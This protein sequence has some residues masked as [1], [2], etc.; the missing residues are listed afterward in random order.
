MRN[1]FLVILFSWLFSSLALQPAEAS[2]KS[3]SKQDLHH[4]IQ[5]LQRAQDLRQQ[6]I[7]LQKMPQ[8][9]PQMAAGSIAGT[10][11]GLNDAD[12]STAFVEAFTVDSIID[13]NTTYKALGTV[14]RDGSYQIDSLT[15]GRYYVCAWADGYLFKY[16][17]NVLVQSEAIPVTVDAGQVTRDIHFKMERIVPGTGAISGRV[18]RENTGAPIYGEIY[19]F[20]LEDPMASGWA[21]TDRSGYY[22][23][24]GLKT[25]NYYAYCWSNGCLTEY[26]DNVFTLEAATPIPVTEPNETREINFTLTTGGMISGQITNETGQPVAGVYVEAYTAKNDSTGGWEDGGITWSHYG[27]AMSDAEGRYLISGLYSADYFVRANYWNMW[28]S[29]GEWYPNAATQEEATPVP[30]MADQETSGIDF[31]LPIRNYS[32][33]IS[34]QVMNSA[35]EPIPGAYVQVQSTDVFPSMP[36]VWAYAYTDEKGNYRIENLPGGNY[37]ISAWAQSGWQF[38]QRWWQDADT[39]EQA[40]PVTVN[41]NQGADGIDFKLPLKI[42]TVT[43]AGRVLADDQHPLWGAN[44]QITPV[45]NQNSG[46]YLWAYGNSDSTGAWQVTGLPAGEYIVSASHW[47]DEKFGQQWYDHADSLAAA[48]PIVM[49]DYEKKTDIDFFLTLKPIWAKIAGTVIDAATKQP[50]PRAY[51]EVTPLYQPND[52]SFA[53]WRFGNYNAVTDE[54]G[55]FQFN[56]LWEAKYLIAVYANGAFQY[57]NAAPT[58]ATATPLAVIGGDSLEVAFEL[59]L[60]NEGPGSISGTVVSEGGSTPFD[61]AVIKALPV[62]N[63]AQTGIFYTAVTDPDGAY[64]LKGLPVGE[65]VVQSFAPYTIGEYY[66]NVF[67]PSLATVIS[68]DGVNPV[69]GIDFELPLIRYM[70]NWEGDA[71]NG[72]NNSGVFG[73]VTDAQQKSLTDV[74]IYL[75]D[76]ANQPVSFTRSGVDGSFE[77]TGIPAG[78]YVVQA[79]KLGY[80]TQF[81]GNVDDFSAAVAVEVGVGRIEV[82]LILPTKGNT[83]IDDATR[84]PRQLELLGNYPNPFNPE[85][86]IQFALPAAMHVRLRIFDLTGAEVAILQDGLLP[87]GAQ[88]VVW[89]GTNRQGRQVSSGVYLYRL[90][91]AASTLTGKMILMR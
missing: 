14:N 17:D 21:I 90:E 60:Q 68:V 89:N 35:G 39:Y 51:V 9:H 64:A 34:G 69:I 37:F 44:I 3:F 24:S 71:R 91:S 74:T 59:T 8:P 27:S 63:A 76:D 36:Y 22:V 42:G 53:P 32:G 6:A 18:T 67:D 23:I 25:G 30:V 56:W 26:Y 31:Q 48:T 88:S 65:Y 58:A 66:D 4:R 70:K 72:T 62:G 57:Y 41:E 61:I 85:T 20:S 28:W 7:R 45:D 83:G 1:K 84:L 29:V 5:A 11:F 38:V 10:L 75:L 46:I 13:P 73:R 43:L 81:N 19:V 49:A 55:R 52:R 80:E 87:A 77:L 16:F 47:M 15:T 54:K 50:L 79:S 40:T 78:N 12:L 86:R 33:S 82:N 2:L